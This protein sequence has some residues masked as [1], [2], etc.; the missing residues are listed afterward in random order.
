MAEPSVQGCIHSVFR[1]EIPARAFYQLIGQKT[2]GF[3]LGFFMP[4]F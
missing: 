4:V 2:P 3:V 1:R